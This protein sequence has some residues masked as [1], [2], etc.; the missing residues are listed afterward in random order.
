MRVMTG[1]ALK[2]VKDAEANGGVPPPTPNK[3][4]KRKA[5]A[6]ATT[7]A[8]GDVDDAESV[9]KPLAKKGRKAKGEAKKAGGEFGSPLGENLSC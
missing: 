4:K 9:L 8:E 1:A 5:V 2:K 3:G 7:T 6:T